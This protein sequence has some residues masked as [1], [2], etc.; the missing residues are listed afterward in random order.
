MAFSEPTNL[1]SNRKKELESEIN[2]SH[3]TKDI[4]KLSLLQSQWVHRYGLDNLPTNSVKSNFSEQLVK[5]LINEPLTTP[6]LDDIQ[7]EDLLDQ[8]NSDQEEIQDPLVDSRNNL[9]SLIDEKTSSNVETEPT[10]DQEQLVE[11]ENNKSDFL[12]FTRTIEPPPIS[13]NKLRKW[14]PLI[15]EEIPKAS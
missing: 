15:E 11:T 6:I 8:I 3:L 13:K 5:P 9:N 2:Q 4:K 7:S 14:L 12:P 1:L 10:E